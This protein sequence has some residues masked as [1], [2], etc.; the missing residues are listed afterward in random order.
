M[1]D[2]VPFRV[3]AGIAVSL[4]VSLVTI[5]VHYHSATDDEGDEDELDFEPVYTDG[6]GRF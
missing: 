2:G 1:I 6:F 3:A 5:E 4:G